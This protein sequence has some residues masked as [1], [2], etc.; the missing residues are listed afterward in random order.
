MF[1][2]PWRIKQVIPQ[3]WMAMQAKQK[4]RTTA[5]SWRGALKATRRSKRRSGGRRLGFGIAPDLP[6]GVE[7][8]TRLPWLGWMR[9]RTAALPA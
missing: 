4:T 8:R 9:F 7:H 3:Y 1:M 6:M 2:D 5:G